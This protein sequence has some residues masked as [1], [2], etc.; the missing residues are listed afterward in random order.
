MTSHPPGDVTDLLAAWGQGETAALDRLLPLVYDDLRRLAHGRLRHERPDHTLRTTALVHEACL[1]LMGQR[2]ADWESRGQFLAL[3]ARAMRRILVD[4]AR[5]RQAEKRGGPQPRVSPLDESVADVSPAQ[6]VLALDDCLEALASFDERKARMVELRF[7][8]G[9]SIEE[10]AQVLG[11]S[12]G[13]VMRDWT[14]T[15]AWLHRAL[16]GSR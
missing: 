14:L 8:G 2:K 10:T 5:R 4:H 16:L 9:L 15:K 12:P 7:F 1:R 6:D 3:A 11:V 13:T